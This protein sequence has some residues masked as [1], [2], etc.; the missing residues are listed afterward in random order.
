MLDV[1]MKNL[2]P[3]ANGQGALVCFNQNSGTVTAEQ[4][5]FMVQG[6]VA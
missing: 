3:A 5:G 4:Y 1:C 6:T 2:P